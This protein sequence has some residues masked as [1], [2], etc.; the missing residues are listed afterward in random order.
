L[1]AGD[2]EDVFARD[3]L[4]LVLFVDPLGGA[5]GEAGD[6]GGDRFDFFF[7]RVAVAFVGDFEEEEAAAVEVG[8]ARERL[9]RGPACFGPS[10]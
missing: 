1:C 9:A 8:R 6:E 2:D 10:T 7:G 3:A 5:G 4:G